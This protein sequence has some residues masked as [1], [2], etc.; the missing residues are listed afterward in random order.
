MNRKCFH[1]PSNWLDYRF[2]CGESK[3]E[4]KIQGHQASFRDVEL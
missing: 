4:I 2:E 3:N 1:I